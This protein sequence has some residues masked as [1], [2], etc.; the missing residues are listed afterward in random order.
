MAV[1]AVEDSSWETLVCVTI[2][3]LCC[4]SVL[5]APFV[6]AVLSGISWEGGKGS[7]GQSGVGGFWLQ[8]CFPAAGGRGSCLVLHLGLLLL[9]SDL[10]DTLGESFDFLGGGGGGRG[11]NFGLCFFGGGGGILYF[12]FLLF[13]LLTRAWAFY[14]SRVSNAEISTCRRAFGP[15]LGEA[16]REIYTHISNS[17]SSSA[18]EQPTRVRVCK[19]AVCCVMLH[20]IVLSYF[21]L[22]AVINS[23]CS[24]IV[25][26]HIASGNMSRSPRTAQVRNKF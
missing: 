13:F 6:C 11:V 7:G 1:N 18:K 23:R 22:A 14:K 19:P 15:H 10:L 26:M 16:N 9:V 8:C 21:T 20:C 24:Y 3:V 25:L 17:A 12:F 2:S 5:H 4:G